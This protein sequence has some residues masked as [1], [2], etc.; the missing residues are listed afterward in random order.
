MN[1]RF[2]NRKGVAL[3]IVILMIV[4]LA[5]IGIYLANL[6]SIYLET[7]PLYYYRASVEFISDSGLERGKE[8]LRD[9][10]GN[11][12]P[13]RP[14]ANCLLYCDP[15]CDKCT[16]PAPCSCSYTDPNCD[17]C[18]LEENITIL[19]GGRSANYK[20]YV[21]GRRNNPTLKVKAEL[22]GLI[23]VVQTNP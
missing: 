16:C 6:G 22:E 3:V 18:Y 11:T 15:V 7:S 14:W 17:E 23:E 13:W 2:I 4:I 1:K 10:V 12:Y 8:L 9:K 19:P 21:S 5:L 20:I